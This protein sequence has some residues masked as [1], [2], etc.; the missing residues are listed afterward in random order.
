MT[1]D[2]PSYTMTATSPKLAVETNP[3]GAFSA[4]QGK[5]YAQNRRSYS[6]KL[7]DSIVDFHKATGGQLKS[8]LDVGCGPGVAVRDLGPLFTTAVGIDPSRGMV[9]T[10]RSLGGSCAGPAPI[11]FEVSSA[12]ELGCNLASRIPDGSVDLIVAANSA[13][14]FCMERFWAA[15][16]RVLRPGGS[17]ALWASTP[18]GMHPSGM[19]LC[20]PPK[21]QL[22][23]WP[24]ELS[25]GNLPLSESAQRSRD[26]S[27]P[28]NHT[29]RRDGAVRE[30]RA[31]QGFR[32][33]SED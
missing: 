6:P 12:E 5:S 14:Y 17:V 32:C 3:W 1:V 20:P 9:D 30:I 10:A 2:G 15:A 23:M 25:Q 8:L 16:A 4:Q 19:V 18:V 13:H 22:Q 33:R 24:H 27:S 21:H 31:Q 26:R 7:Y 29:C 11:R 28:G